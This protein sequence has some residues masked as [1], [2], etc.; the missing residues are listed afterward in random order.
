MSKNNFQDV[1]NM[2]HYFGIEIK[3]TPA[4]MSSA[5]LKERSDFLQEELDEFKAA[6]AQQDMCEMADALIDIVVVA[7]GTAAMMGLPWDSL[8][9]DVLRA[10]MA[11]QRGVGKRGYAVDLIKPKNWVPPQTMYHLLMA[12]YHPSYRE[13]IVQHE[14][15]RLCQQDA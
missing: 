6:V 4:H 12:G 7:M 9:D 15:K 11:K 5:Q 10:N 14:E 3:Y 1:V 8:W 13:L 2:H